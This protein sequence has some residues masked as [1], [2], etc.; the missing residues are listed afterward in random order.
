MSE[1][2]FISY[3][4][5][6]EIAGLIM[7]GLI[8]AL[9]LYTSPKK[10]Y[11]FKYIFWGIFLSI[12]AILVQISIVHVANNPG[13][14]FNRYLFM[15]QLL[16]FLILYNG[17]L[18]CIF[19]YVNMMSIVRRAQRKD[20]I[21]MY[22]ILSAVYITGV[23]I[24]IAASHFYSF[25]VDGIDISHFVKYYCGAGIVCAVICF[26]ATLSNRLNV[27]RVIWYAVITIVPIDICLLLFQLLTI[28]RFHSIFMSMSYVPVFALGYVLF[29]SNP[30]DELTGS[31]NIYGLIAYLDKYI[32]K[33]KMF[34]SYIDLKYPNVESF[35][36]NV[37]EIFMKA[38][39]ICRSLEAIR[40]KVKLYR[41]SED[42]FVAII[43][44]SEYQKFL[45]VINNIRGALDGARADMAV[46]INYIMISGEVYPE[47]ETA[48]KSRQ[49]FQYMSRRYKDQ[50]SSH[51]YIAKPTDFDEFIEEYEVAVTLEDIRNRLDLDDDR[52]VVYAQPI[53]SVETGSFRGAEALTRLKIG[54]KLVNPDRFIPIAEESG[55]I[56]A[57]SCIVLN[58][59]CKAIVEFEEFYDFDALSINISSKEIS[60]KNAY[61]DLMDIIEKYDIDVSKIRFEIT[62]SAMFENYEMANENMNS[63]TKAGIHFYL[64]DFG[65]GY[66]SF[67]RIMNC[68]VKTIKFDKTLLYKSLDDER[69]DDIMTYM[70]EVF[71]KNGYITLVEG[72]EDESQSQYSMERG[73]DYIQGYLYAKPEP[74][75]EMKKYFD[76]KNKF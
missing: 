73:F 45:G 58:K 61:Y 47:I 34:L 70:I 63:L 56:H 18:Y 33:R 5:I 60:H 55:T 31:Q 69:M 67:E 40:P 4:Y 57:I 3:N 62:E 66:S 7:A 8:L 44:V 37:D 38:V 25:E 54:D 21:L 52:V 9:L 74:L 17:I 59:V 42:K 71:K 19:S 10:S 20:F 43:E 24:E 49:Y 72:V 32:G 46:P 68:P 11:V 51:F 1:N 64:D 13:L 12:A 76:R 48:T 53:Y 28:D 22:A 16:V 26:N 15:G 14:Y 2:V 41:A 36:N 65:T 23:I 50:N 39:S 6:G 27:A 30:Y 75:E 35:G 29:H